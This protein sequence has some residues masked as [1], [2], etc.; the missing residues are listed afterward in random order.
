MNTIF[1]FKATKS[2]NGTQY[3]VDLGQ[4][5]LDGLHGDTLT[6]Y[7]TAHAKVELQNKKGA[8]LR[9]SENVEGAKDVL[10]HFGY[11]NATVEVYVPTVKPRKELTLQDIRNALAT[12][13]LTK[14]Q[15]ETAIA[16]K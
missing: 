4:N 12:G 10:T 5:I 3:Q 2:G 7:A 6:A 15:L 14:A 16:Q 11:P 8:L 1:T 9:A 13:K